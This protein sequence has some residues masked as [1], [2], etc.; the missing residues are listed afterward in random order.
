MASSDH[1]VGELKV[2][3]RWLRIACSTSLLLALVCLTL[4]FA[5]RAATTGVR[6]LTSGAFYASHLFQ[7]GSEISNISIFG[8]MI[9]GAVITVLTPLQLI[10]P[11]RKAVPSLHKGLGYVLIFGGLLSSVGGLVYIIANGTVGGPVMSLGFA[12]Y[13][14]CVLVCT[15]QTVRFARQR[16]FMR[17]REWALRLFVL[18]IGSWLYRVHYWLWYDATGGLWMG[19]QF[20]GPFDHVQAFAFYVPYLLAVEV[21]LR[22]PF[23]SNAY[24]RWKGRKDE[25]NVDTSS[26]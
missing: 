22:I 8:H 6:A 3:W 9:A 24:L 16:S 20:S 26:V 12:G 18:A 7:V 19:P 21:Y 1:A 25:P 4:P 14:L 10:G 13:G 2:D 15:L 23:R 17:H 11:L 5:E